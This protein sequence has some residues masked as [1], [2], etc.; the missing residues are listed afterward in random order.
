MTDIKLS[1]RDILGILSDL[2]P[3]LAHQ[4]MEGS[5]PSLSMAAAIDGLPIFNRTYCGDEGKIQSLP[6]GQGPLYEVGS[7]SKT[8]TNIAIFRLAEQGLI[9]LG[10]PIVRYIPELPPALSYLT[11][12]DLMRHK[13]PLGTLERKSRLKLPKKISSERL[14]LKLRAVGTNIAGNGHGKWDYSNIGISLLGMIIE[15]TSG[16][17]YH[18]YVVTNLLRPHGLQDIFPSVRSM[19]EMDRRRIA[20]GHDW[21]QQKTNTGERAALNP[22]GGFVATPLAMS[23]F[24]GLLLSGKILSPR[25]TK[26]LFEDTVNV[27]Q[28]KLRV[29]AGVNHFNMPAVPSADNPPPTSPTIKVIGHGGWRP[30][31]GA[32]ALSDGHLTVSLMINAHEVPANA[33]HRYTGYTSIFPVCV[34]IFQKLHKLKAQTDT[35]EPNIPILRRPCMDSTFNPEV[36]P[37]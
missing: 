16:K 30:G 4:V 36:A 7:Q 33:E 14:L 6:T 22:S 26:M 37:K 17:P 24:Y 8:V 21:R 19:A 2:D 9:R 27:P 29:A 28:H 15:R 12:S 18:D 35:P 34:Y 11:V 1:E 32:I 31:F 5:I 3:W 23:Q 20:V 10:D 25:H 13:S